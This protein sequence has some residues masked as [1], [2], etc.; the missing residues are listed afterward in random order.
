[1][2]DRTD[3]RF[4]AVIRATAT[5]T[6][7]ALRATTLFSAGGGSAK[8]RRGLA[9]RSER[10]SEMSATRWDD[11]GSVPPPTPLFRDDETRRRRRDWDDWDARDR[12]RDD[13]PSLFSVTLFGFL[14]FAA[15][16]GVGYVASGARESLWDNGPRAR[17]QRARAEA[18]DLGMCQPQCDYVNNA[19]PR[20][21][22]IYN[23]TWR[24]GLADR[25]DMYSGI[26]AQLAALTCARIALMPPTLALDPGHN[27]GVYMPNEWRWDTYIA[28]RSLVPFASPLDVDAYYDYASYDE[29]A[30]DKV[31]REPVLMDWSNDAVVIARDYMD[32]YNN[33]GVVIFGD[34]ADALTDDK[35]LENLRRAI[36]C[37]RNGVPFIWKMNFEITWGQRYD[38]WVREFVGDDP[39]N[40][41][42]MYAVKQA[43][44]E[45]EL[46]AIGAL[47]PGVG[48]RECTLAEVTTSDVISRLADIA[49]ARALYASGLGGGSG[50]ESVEE[51]AWDAGM[52]EDASGA[53]FA[54]LHARRGDEVAWCDTSPEALDDFVECAL[55]N[56]TDPDVRAGKV[57]VIWFTDETE[58][59]YWK[60]S[61]A[62]MRAGMLRYIRRDGGDHFPGVV[63]GESLV[64]ATVEEMLVRVADEMGVD[65]GGIGAD[66]RHAG[67]NY[68]RYQI[69][70]EMMQR[71]EANADAYWNIHF[72]YRGGKPFK[73]GTCAKGRGHPCAR[74]GPVLRMARGEEDALA[75]FDD[76][77][78]IGKNA[79]L[80]GG[81]ELQREREA[82]KANATAD[83]TTN[84]DP[85]GVV[86]AERDEND[87]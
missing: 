33:P 22:I 6:P 83:I 85:G 20:S 17:D 55:A 19:A 41:G 5:S 66:R 9:S 12:Y 50:E 49:T 60:E 70:V 16:V 54:A 72:S 1:M 56:A 75:E 52:S 3:A 42:L 39:K 59:W 46:R 62:S 84:T 80:V 2:A 67:D 86:R 21:L 31:P 27:N 24:A 32:P 38:W 79:F 40:A 76:L 14:F 11:Y 71:A 18:A 57:P 37:A 45:R 23:T 65:V 73:Y 81:V 35:I 64:N 4:H 47:D 26:L 15:L 13:G 61:T 30:F 43:S 29:E 8:S 77:L 36:E 69:G 53:K 87:G 78:D 82:L 74:D 51:P 48:L 28:N 7:R 44:L 25:Q 58:E 10:P 34:H 63:Y 68:L